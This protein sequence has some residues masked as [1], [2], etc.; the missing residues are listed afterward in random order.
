MCFPNLSKMQVKIEQ[1]FLTLYSFAACLCLHEAAR[2]M[3]YKNSLQ[4]S[5]L[6]EN[7]IS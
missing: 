2:F 1:I 3:T 4:I 6:T 5:D 7:D